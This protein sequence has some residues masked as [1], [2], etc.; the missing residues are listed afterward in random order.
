MIDF[1]LESQGFTALHLA[2]LRHDPADVRA[3][4]AQG[5]DPNAE[6]DLGRTP[7]SC[8]LSGLEST[9][10]NARRSRADALR[11]LLAAGADLDRAPRL[12]PRPREL[13]PFSLR[14]TVAAWESQ[15]RSID[16]KSALEK[17]I[18]VVAPRSMRSR[19]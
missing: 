6:D 19:L 4:L 17:A 12:G 14:T 2:A 5:L 16:E 13:V 10:G 15:Q 11:L 9:N 1:S 3:A 8:V 7:L 18:S